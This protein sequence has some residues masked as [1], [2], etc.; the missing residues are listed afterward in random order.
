MQP[1]S[2]A[3][4]I[5]HREAPCC[6]CL[7]LEWS[8]LAP[9]LADEV[10]ESLEVLLCRRQAP[11]GTLFA[12]AVLEDP[13]RLLDDR[14]T[15][16]GTSR[17]DGGQLSLP[18]DHV[19]LTAHAGIAQHLLDVE[20]TTRGAVDGVLRVPRAKQRPRD[21]HLG[22]LDR[23][24]T[25]CIVDGQSDFCPAE[26]RPVG[27]AH[28]D[29]VFH[30]RAAKRPGALRAEHPRHRVNDV[31]LPRPIGADHDGDPGLELERGR[32][33]ERLEPLHRQSLQVHRGDPSNAD[34]G[35]R[36]PKE[37]RSG[38]ARRS[39]RSGS[40]RSSRSSAAGASP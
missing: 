5:E 12:S 14:A 25:I 6:S 32:V 40:A 31:G 2:L 10:T 34:G 1:E 13:G 24:R 18:D 23:K 26:R 16:F 27:G 29:D 4:L 22:H 35:R 11:L 21:G 7:A 19:L 37:P 9:D 20:K 36:R 30:L 33:S 17:E 38:P 8:H 15:V 39:I 3:L 28:E